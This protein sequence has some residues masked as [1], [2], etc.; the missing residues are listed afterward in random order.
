[1]ILQNS[2]LEKFRKNQRKTQQHALLL[3]NPVKLFSTF[4]FRKTAFELMYWCH[5]GKCVVYLIMG[6]SDNKHKIAVQ[7]TKNW[8]AF[9]KK[10]SV[11]FIESYT[12]REKCPYLVIFWSVFLGI[13]I[14]YDD[15]QSKSLYSVRMQEN[16][17]QKN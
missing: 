15:L 5:C 1:M 2:C 8:K 16:V 7:A 14:E 11:L 10:E 17:D 3:V 12:L 13:C 4:L 6:F 9:N